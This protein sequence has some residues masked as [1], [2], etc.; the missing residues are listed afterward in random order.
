MSFDR[1][2]NYFDHS[3]SWMNVVSTLLPGELTV[4]IYDMHSP[5]FTLSW[6]W[7]SLSFVIENSRILSTTHHYKASLFISKHFFMECFRTDSMFPALPPKVQWADETLRI[8]DLLTG[9]TWHGRVLLGSRTLVELGTRWW[10]VVVKHPETRG[11]FEAILDGNIFET[12]GVGEKPPVEIAQIDAQSWGWIWPCSRWR[13][14]T[15]C[16][17]AINTHQWHSSTV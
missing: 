4:D 15:E 3:N 1:A 6:L 9:A 2:T 5:W 14:P 12:K 8:R 10:L 17:W 11:R 7:W 16:D 13:G